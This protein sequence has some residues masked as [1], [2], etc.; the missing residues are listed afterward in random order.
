M[1]YVMA[2]T[3]EEAFLELERAE[4]HG[5]L[6]AGG[7]DVVIGIE[8]GKIQVSQ[9]VDVTRIPGFTDIRVEGEYLYIG[10]AAN[11]TQISRSPLVKEHVPS[12]AKAAARVGSTQ[13]GNVGTLAGN[14]ISAQ[15]AADAAMALAVLDAL[16]Y[17][18]SGHARERTVPMAEMY[19]DIGRSA[20]DSAR[21]IVTRIRIP[22]LAKDEAASFMRLELRKTL[23]LP[24]LNASAATKI[25]G[26]SLVWAKIAMGP[27]GVGPVRAKKAEEWLVGKPVTAETI[28]EAADLA[29]GDANLRS[30]LLRGTREYRSTTLPVLIRRALADC[31]GQLGYGGD[32]A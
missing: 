3:I 8:E 7:T 6:I 28:R 11:L 24:M 26:G 21:E 9:L 19:K 22:V 25:K 23:A 31:A 29:L 10:A 20:I 13:I 18:Y 17:V 14:V 5:K 15:P 12:L 16:F 2:A 1:N 27:A 32:F 4:G 30:S